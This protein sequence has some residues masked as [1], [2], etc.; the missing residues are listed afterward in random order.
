M[1]GDTTSLTILGVSAPDAAALR[2]W[3]PVLSGPDGAE[4]AGWLTCETS[5]QPGARLWENGDDNRTYLNDAKGTA[6]PTFSPTDWKGGAD[7][8][9]RS[10][11]AR[12]RGC[13]YLD[14]RC[15]RCT[16][17]A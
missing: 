16:S 5:D 13:N 9:T 3:G 11:L 14:I 10:V 8:W 6:A 15:M 1:L 2:L 12:E 4:R 7:T 17:L